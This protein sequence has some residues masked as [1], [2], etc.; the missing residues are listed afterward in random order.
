MPRLVRLVGPAALLLVALLATLAALAYGGGSAAQL[1]ADPGPVVRWGLP[2]A[3]LLVNI[4]AAGT[5][6]AL[7]LAVFALSPREREFNVALD[8]SAASAAVFTVAAASTGFLTF[9]QVTNVSFSFDDR[10]SATMGQFFSQI[11][12]GQA[13]LGTTLIAAVVTVLCL[14]LIHI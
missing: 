11:E 3:K 5:I 14:S 8:F 9:L 10:F 6:G 12:I 4:G 2:V 1:L 13:W 7:V